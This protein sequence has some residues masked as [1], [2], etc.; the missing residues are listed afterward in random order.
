[1]AFMAEV[2]TISDEA[3]AKVLEVR[4]DEPESERLALW[5]EV[6]GEQAGAYTYLMEFRPADEV[7]DDV[8]VQHHDDLPVAIPESSVDKLRGATLELSGGGM[9]MQNPNR[10][11]PESPAVRADRPPA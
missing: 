1:M 2:L 3:R 5:V 11:L 9:V 10:P 4:S 8:L 7:G 6:N